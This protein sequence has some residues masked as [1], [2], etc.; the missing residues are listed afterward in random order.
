MQ[1]LAIY[2]EKTHE[3]EIIREDG[4]HIKRKIAEFTPNIRKVLGVQV[5]GKEVWVLVGP[6]TISPSIRPNLK[7][8]YNIITGA[9]TGSRSI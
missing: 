4:H 1:P 2:H 5:V 8:I 6:V 3:L 9:Y 7:Y